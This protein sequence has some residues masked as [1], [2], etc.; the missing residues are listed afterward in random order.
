MFQDTTPS[1]QQNYAARITA[2]SPMV[3]PRLGTQPTMASKQT[4]QSSSSSQAPMT[5][6]PPLCDGACGTLPRA[7]QPLGAV[8]RQE[9]AQAAQAL[10]KLG[11]AM[12]TRPGGRS[13]RD[14]V[15]MAM[16]TLLACAEMCMLVVAVPLWMMLPGAMFAAWMGFCAIVVA[17]MCRMLNGRGQLHQC[18]AGSEGWMMGQDG[19]DEKWLFVGGMGMSAR[20]CHR[21]TLP[22]LA[23]LFSR[24]MTCVCVPTMGLPFDM[25]AMML[26]RCMLLPSQ[27]RRSLYTQMR[28][29]LLDDSMRRCVVL[30]H[31]HSAI[32]VSQAA[33][34]LCADLPAEKLCKL[35]IYTFGA[36][37]CEFVLPLG[38]DNLQPEPA[39]PADMSN[40]PHRGVHVEHFA[41]TDDPFAQLG[42]LQSVR[43]NMDGRFCGG[44]FIMNNNHQQGMANSNGAL[45]RPS[46]GIM[47]E[48]YLHALFP[49]QL[50]PQQPNARSALDAIMAIDRD[51]A[52]K[53]EI[54]AMSNYYTASRA[55]KDSGSKR[56]SWT[57]LA[58]AATA[59]GAHGHQKNGVSAGMV[60][61]E[62]ARKGCKNCDGHRGREVSWLVRY[63]AI[64]QIGDNVCVPR[65]LAESSVS[66]SPGSD[67]VK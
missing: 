31:N 40:E 23:K 38:E 29:A 55:R 26:Q 18:A 37:A 67:D 28:C 46:S 20:Y 6:I 11:W 30:C 17:S 54:T 24:P 22:M 61:L 48:D 66:S 56:L 51:C 8:L 13:W 63:V 64:G 35:E 21:T 7:Q 19:D 58:A 3:S 5:Y 27:A 65:G 44:V 42:V 15:D 9:L 60:G 62:M 43:K 36:A 1:S 10:P 34:Q 45:P 12:F 14:M 32:I 41:M 39:H 25:I 2:S 59:N 57:G 16:H 50:L 33:S 52:E 47:M 4:S 53:R 49:V